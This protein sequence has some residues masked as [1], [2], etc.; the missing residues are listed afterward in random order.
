MSIKQLLRP[1]ILITLL[2]FSA[3]VSAQILIPDSSPSEAQ[4]K[5]E[6][7]GLKTETSSI[8]LKAMNWASFQVK[9]VE[10]ESQQIR[11]GLAYMISSGLV[12]TG[13]T[14]GYSNV[15][16]PIEKWVYSFSQ[17]LSIAAFGYGYY[18][19]HIGS[20]ERNFYELL[21]SSRSLSDQQRDELV[22]NYIALREKQKETNKWIHFSTY[23]ALAALNIY[24]ASRERNPDVKNSMYFLGGISALAA[25]SIQF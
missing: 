3:K 11:T 18:Q 5:K 25:I 15:N 4:P 16:S 1:F 20:S 23:T 17:S 24:Q 19:Y 10:L 9:M 14:I 7:F 8:D 12:F 21:S 13:A 22:K 6:L 2:A